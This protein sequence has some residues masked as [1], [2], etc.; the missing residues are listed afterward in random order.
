MPSY[1]ITVLE[2]QAF[3]LDHCMCYKCVMYV[4][5]Y[6]GLGENIIKPID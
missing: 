2:I 5:I 1:I 3:L 4:C 6:G